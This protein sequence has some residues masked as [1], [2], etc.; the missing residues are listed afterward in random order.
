MVVACGALICGALAAGCSTSSSGTHP[1]T[2][3]VRSSSSST[4]TGPVGSTTT[5][6]AV[7]STTS[8]SAA[9]PAPVDASIEVYGDCR[10]PSVEPSEIVM[11]CADGGA[12][13]EALHWTSW[14]ANGA[15]AVGTLAYKTCVPDCATG[16]SRTIPDDVVTL[17]VPVTGATGQL[18]WSEI[19]ESVEPP[20]YETGPDHGG[21][22]P[23]PTRPD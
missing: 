5:S 19:Q 20:G 8:S 22:Q 11:A 16:G 21:P 15:T 23:L 18:V 4:T 9:A 6:T 3:P 14:T 13:A 12:V 10:H 1:T 7:G 2:P 17:T